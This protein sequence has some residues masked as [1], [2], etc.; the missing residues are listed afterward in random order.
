MFRRHASN[1]S[2]GNGPSK[3]DVQAEAARMATG[4]VA[5][6]ANKPYNKL[7]LCIIIDLIGCVVASV[8]LPYHLPSCSDN[9][10]QTVQ[11]STGTP[12][13]R[14]QGSRP[15][16]CSPYSTAAPASVSALLP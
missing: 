12:A 8:N 7:F 16:C 1:N 2:N 13:H 4:F 3:E 11:L 15:V 10:G 5:D 6:A 9:T 14:P